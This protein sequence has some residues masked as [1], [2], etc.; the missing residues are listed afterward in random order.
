MTFRKG[1]L[2]RSRK[3]G[4]FYIVYSEGKNLDDEWVWCK[5]LSPKRF[6]SRPSDAFLF[7]KQ[8]LELVGNNYRVKGE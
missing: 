6:C 8:R 5:P 7:D 2:V 4:D 1:Q 3:Y